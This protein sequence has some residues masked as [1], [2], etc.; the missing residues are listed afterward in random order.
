MSSCS[1][2]STPPSPRI[3]PHFSVMMIRKYIQNNSGCSLLDIQKHFD[4]Y[5][6]FTPTNKLPD[7]ALNRNIKHMVFIFDTTKSFWEALEKV[8]DM[9]DL[10]MY[11]SP[12]N[13]KKQSNA[14][15]FANKR[16]YVFVPVIVYIKSNDL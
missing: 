5:G 15:A 16:N 14:V 9:N 8:L 7:N 3:R 6:N 1:C 13:H 2:L 4:A 10:I 11:I 12:N